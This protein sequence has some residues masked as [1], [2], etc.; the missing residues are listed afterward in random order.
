MS[1][2]FE[3]FFGEKLENHEFCGFRQQGDISD[4]FYIIF[5]LLFDYVLRKYRKYYIFRLLFLI[6]LEAS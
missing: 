3:M 6:I 4:L 5:I 1:F 2:I